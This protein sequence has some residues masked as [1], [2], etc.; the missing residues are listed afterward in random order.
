MKRCT[1]THEAAGFGTIP[2][3][4]LW[5]DDSEYITDDNTEHFVDVEAEP[6]KAKPK[7]SKAVS[8]AFKNLAEGD[9]V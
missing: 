9:D 3:G 2:A 1:T 8:A 4:S 7:K 5:A 6:V